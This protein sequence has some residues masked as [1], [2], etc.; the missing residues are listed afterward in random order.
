[1]ERP[2]VEELQTGAGGPGP[3]VAA[4]ERAAL[5]L[6]AVLVAAGTI[7]IGTAFLLFQFVL[8]I[9]RPLEELVHELET[10]Q[11]ANGAMVRVIDL[12]GVEPN[13]LDEGTWDGADAPAASEEL[14]NVAATPA[15]PPFESVTVL[16]NPDEAESEA[17]P[18]GAGPVVEAVATASV[19][20]TLEGAQRDLRERFVGTDLATA[21]DDLLGARRTD[22]SREPLRATALFVTPVRSDTVLGFQV[23]ALGANLH[24]HK[25]SLRDLGQLCE[26]G[27]ETLIS[28]GLGE[29]DVIL[30]AV[31]NRV[32][33]VV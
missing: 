20:E 33:N 12:L 22:Q 8:L 16:D 7:T 18:V 24:L 25:H 26:C 23:H 30:K 29:R 3:G 14:R 2:G 31:R 5:V 9:A 19:A 1:M 13:V 11:K 28:V 17:G 6:G 32:P 27:V 21:P 15:A 4:L 10:V